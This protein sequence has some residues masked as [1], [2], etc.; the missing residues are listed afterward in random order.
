MAETRT[1]E[2]GNT[3]EVAAIRAF[4]ARLLADDLLVDE[5]NGLIF[6]HVVA[7]R[8]HRSVVA[9]SLRPIIEEILGAAT[10]ADWQAVADQLIAEAREIDGEV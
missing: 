6:E 10:A 8:Y 9:E 1:T 3:V 4:L 5:V 2:Q 7:G